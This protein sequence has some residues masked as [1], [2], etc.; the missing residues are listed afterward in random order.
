[1]VTP[2]PEI[3]PASPPSDEFP[4]IVYDPAEPAESAARLER[5]GVAAYQRRDYAEAERLFTQ[6]V[7]EQQD[8]AQCHRGL[9]IV[10]AGRDDARAVRELRRYLQL[11]PGARDKALVERLIK[12]LEHPGS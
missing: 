10:L 2:E 12:R 4:E 5:E 11:R 9:G 8:L 6:C 3:V 1:V 7:T